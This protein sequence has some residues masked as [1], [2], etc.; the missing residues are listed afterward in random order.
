MSEIMSGE[1]FLKRAVENHS[2]DNNKYVTPKFH[3]ATVNH[4]EIRMFDN[5]VEIEMGADP[6]P[7]L[8][9]FEL[10][11]YIMFPYLDHGTNMANILMNIIRACGAKTLSGC[12]G[13][14]CMVKYNT[15]A[16]IVSFQIPGSSEEFNLADYCHHLDGNVMCKRSPW[17]DGYK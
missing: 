10:R 16:K 11:L 12:I 7:S 13:Q 15:F 14:S 5:R 2:L 3:Q 1:E 8:G 17:V 4:A 9:D 6:D